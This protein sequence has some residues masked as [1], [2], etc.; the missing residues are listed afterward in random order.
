MPKRVL[1]VEDDPSTSAYLTAG[2]RQ[3]G[4]TVET[5]ANGPDALHLALS[6]T[7]DAVVL[8]R[9]LPGLD[10]LSVLRAL[11][12]ASKTTPVLILS[13]LAHADERING[14]RAGADD[15]L[16]K[17]YAFSELCLRLEN[18][19]R[20]GGSAVGDAVL[21]CADLE[22]NLVARKVTRGARV[23]DL[24]PREFQILEELLRAKDRVVTRTHL[25]E[26]VWDYRFD[27][28]TTLID[29]HVSRLRKKLD[30]P[31]EAPLLHTVRGV[32][33]RLSAAP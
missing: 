26:R 1:V 16:A 18:L 29:T 15:Y 2:L 8:D 6:E 12:A 27:P 9:N 20:K 17:P 11:R 14:L 7:F 24:L 5:A 28:H 21:H 23:V 32:G 30:A 4:M 19:M 25:L 22:M 3:E 10:G 33:Y 31:G 13:A